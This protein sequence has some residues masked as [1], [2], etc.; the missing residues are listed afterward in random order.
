MPRGVK[1]ELTEEELALKIADLDQK[2][3]KHQRAIAQLKAK[4]KK[5]ADSRKSIAY[6]SLLE[7][8]DQSGKSP[9]EI[10]S[11]IQNC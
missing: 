8:I 9:E 1:K 4:R 5:L 10:L 7:V 3:N 2:I 11:I 6:H